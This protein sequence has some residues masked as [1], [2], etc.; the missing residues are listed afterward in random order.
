MSVLPQ[1]CKHTLHQQ[2]YA[3]HHVVLFA[4]LPH[5]AVYRLYEISAQTFAN[6]NS[7]LIKPTSTDERQS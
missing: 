4:S 6:H 2:V 7:S 3:G 1:E 5:L